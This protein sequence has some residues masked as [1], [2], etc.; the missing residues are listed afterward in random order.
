[1]HKQLKS[2]LIHPCNDN[3]HPHKSKEAIIISKAGKKISVGNIMIMGLI[4]KRY[5]FIRLDDLYNV[6]VCKAYTDMYGTI[7]IIM[8]ITTHLYVF[9]Y[10]HY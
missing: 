5:Q 3:I 9:V 8:S 2:M 1:M 10:L 7:V 6:C 4:L